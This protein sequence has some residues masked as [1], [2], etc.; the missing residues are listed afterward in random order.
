METSSQCI[1]QLISSA[2]LVAIL[3]WIAL[4]GP[5]EEMQMPIQM[6]TSIAILGLTFSF[7]NQIGIECTLSVL[8][9]MS[10]LSILVVPKS[11]SIFLINKTFIADTPNLL[12]FN[13]LS[14]TF[15]TKL[16]T[17]FL[18]YISHFVLYFFRFQ[19]FLIHTWR[20]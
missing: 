13:I 6:E 11:L 14:Q 5:V 15:P 1:L 12:L 20:E 10:I 18:G 4:E 16:L 8:K 2:S 9:L 7:C 19:Q 3:Y 17:I